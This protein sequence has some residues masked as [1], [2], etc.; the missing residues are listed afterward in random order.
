MLGG[1]QEKECYQESHRE[2]R[3]L[4]RKEVA[5]AV[6]S[7]ASYLGEA[8]DNIR[9]FFNKE[10]WFIDSA[11]RKSRTSDAGSSRYSMVTTPTLKLTPASR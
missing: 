6:V 11:A 4:T 2:F 1:Q 8:K 7:F 5:Q 3:Q 9:T 10:T